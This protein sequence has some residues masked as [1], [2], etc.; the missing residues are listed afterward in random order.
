MPRR[1][2]TAAVTTPAAAAPEQLRIDIPDA[3][4]HL[5][6]R[7]LARKHIHPDPEQ[8]RQQA[9]AEL[10]ASIATHGILQPITVRPATPRAGDCPD[11]GRAWSSIFT[12]EEFIIVDGERRWRGA[13]GILDELPA[14]VR[15]DQEADARRLITQL[16]ANTGKPLSP[17][18]EARAYARILEATGMTQSELAD[19]VGVPRTSLNERLALLQLG[20]W[21]PMLEAGTIGISH[22]V[23]ALVPLR[24]VPAK[25]HEQA[26][27]R[28]DRDWRW[29]KRGEGGGISVADFERL[30]EQIYRPI[31]YPLTKSSGYGRQP[32]FN[33]AKHDAECECGGIKFDLGTGTPRRCCGNPG[34]WKPLHKKAIAAKKEAGPAKKGAA[35]K[36]VYLPDGAKV[37]HVGYG[38]VPKGVVALTDSHGRWAS[39]STYGSSDERFDPADLSIDDAQLVELRASYGDGYPIVGTKDV[40]AVKAARAAWQRRFADQANAARADFAGEIEQH[41]EAFAV[42]GPG[43]RKLLESLAA[44]R[45]EELLDLAAALGIVVPDS[46]MRAPQWELGGKLR[47]WLAKHPSET[48]LQLLATAF[49]TTAGRDLKMPGVR[50][51]EA[52]RAALAAI[53]KRKIP[54]L[55]KPKEQ[56][57]KAAAPAPKTVKSERRMPNPM[58]MRPLQ[59]DAALAAVVGDKALPRTEITKKLWSYIKKHRLQGEGDQRRMINADDALRPVFGGKARVSMFEMTKLINAHLVEDGAPAKK[60]K[61][62]PK[63]KQID[64]EEEIEAVDD[65]A[66]DDESKGFEDS[67]DDLWDDASADDLDEELEEVES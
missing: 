8:P 7:Y 21:L 64:L 3:A 41:R 65:D 28:L 48:D 9:D 50:V 35:A 10:R 36:R 49:A 44:H 31:L 5:A 43:V 54:W 30:V 33:T 34:W 2:K 38:G 26:M 39:G 66:G 59:P 17:I 12:A 67:G 29:Q 46:I 42:H 25:Y 18:E 63:A 27:T 24:T 14:L 4:R 16:V 51:E 40:A 1:A 62:A 23:R 15:E 20:P 11:C 22:A 47:A 32:E 45:G 6:V 61:R 52:Q 37:M 60:A 13:D 57:K 55:A 53:A 58:Y 56:P 19:V